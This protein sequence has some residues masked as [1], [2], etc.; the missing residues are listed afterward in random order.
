MAATLENPV[1]FEPLPGEEAAA[2][3]AGTLDGRPPG[4]GRRPPPDEPPPA[5]SSWFEQL[6]A[7]LS[8]EEWEAVVGGS[9]LNKLG[10][11][12]LVIGL[13]LF[14]NY[15]YGHLGPAGRVATGYAVGLALL[16]AGLWLERQERY[17]IFTLGLKGGGWAALYYTSYAVHAI[18][19]SRLIESPALGMLL[20]VGVAAAMIAHAL[21]YR[22]EPMACLAYF[23]GYA[24]LVISPRSDY[25]LLA[26][27]PLL[28]SLLIASY[29]RE[30]DQTPLLGLILSYACYALGYGDVF[31]RP[32][33]PGALVSGKAIL[34]VHWLA[35]EAFDLLEVARGRRSTGAARAVFPVN[36]VGFI[37][38]ALLH[39]PS[40]DPYA[41][42]HFLAM[43]GAGYLV[44][45]LIRAWLRPP[46]GFAP[47][48]PILERALAG[49]YEGAV[50]LT[51][52]L[53]AVALWLRFTGFR[54][55]AGSL[56][57]VEMLFVTGRQ[58][59][60]SF[61]RLLGLL[62]YEL[63]ALYGF[64]L[65]VTVEA[66]REL[67]GLTMKAWTPGLG[68]LIAVGYLDALLLPGEPAEEFDRQ[69]RAGFS[70]AATLLA[71]LCLAS[72]LRGQLHGVAW[73]ALAMIL[74]EVA[75]RTTRPEFAWQAYGLGALAAGTMVVQNLARDAG[76]AAWEPWVALGGP[77]LLTGFTAW[78]LRFGQS[79]NLPL[80][81]VPPVSDLSADVAV[82]ALLGLLWHL[83]PPGLVALGWGVVAVV[84]GEIGY[85]W[86]WPRLRLHL[87]V[88][89]ALTFGRAVMAN[90][91]LLGDTAGLSHRVLT[92]V[93][94]LALFIYEWLRG[95]EEAS[96]SASGSGDGDDGAPLAGEPSS[97]GQ[98]AGQPYPEPF[99]PG[100]MT[101]AERDWQWWWLYPP[102]IMAAMLF[103]FEFGRVGMVTGWALLTVGL[104]AVGRRARLGHLRAQSYLLAV[105]TFLR[106]WGTDFLPPS[107]LPGE[108]DPNRVDRLLAGFAVV[109]AFFI[110]QFQ[111]PRREDPADDG[112]LYPFDRQF[113]SAFCVMGALILTKLIYHEV[114]GHALSIAW[115]CEAALLLAAG[116]ALRDR[117]LRLSGLFLL[118]FCVLKLLVYD[119]AN[120]EGPWRYLSFCL[121]GAL[122]MGISWAYSRFRDK[123]REYF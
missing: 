26:S 30:W 121:V 14:L 62:V 28:A 27:L 3:A 51:T 117:P 68:L 42:P 44:S 60:Q 123:L 9:W 92:V 89:L 116:F 82:G 115:G 41:L 76:P 22:S 39:A 120:L 46:A 7:S 34:V 21:Q 23:I 93:P 88:V 122:V 86:G 69:S 19:A 13:A 80:D 66:A 8:G 106:C 4:F 114:S 98:A 32:P 109:L 52:G 11:L 36:A 48:T 85:G 90:F 49:S 29:R 70:V 5:G 37:G 71:V 99:R 95:A 54:L 87:Q 97:P 1:S 47:A 118:F 84:A 113:R 83:L 96:A 94:L 56:L 10:A 104:V 57:L 53:L 45:T 38:V 64:H 59:R 12:I 58:T 25:S 20:L 33:L 15:S 100:G 101:L 65:M 111:L 16:G 50:S 112:Q 75:R 78:R 107:A 63:G 67:F 6:R 17:Q 108:F 102:T 105:M 24:T 18:D 72:N 31:W 110:A 43:T 119:F 2:T 79:G 61:L 55:I 81:H 74:L 73:L 40:G 35:F 91:T 103:R 77:V